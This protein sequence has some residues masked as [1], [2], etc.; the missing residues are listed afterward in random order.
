MGSNPEIANMENKRIIFS[1]EPDS[2]Q[3]LC[4]GTIKELT[5]GSEINAR[6]NH[7]NNCKTNLKAIF[8]L[9]C[10]NKPKISEV[11]EGD[12]QRLKPVDFV[13]T[14]INEQDYLKLDPHDRKNIFIKNILYKSLPWQQLNRQA[15][16][17]ILI[18]YY[19]KY[20]ENN[21][22]LPVSESVNK[23]SKEYC[24]N[25]D[26]IF[27]WLSD[28]YTKNEDSIIKLKEIFNEFKSSEQFLNLSF[29]QRAQ[30]MY[31]NFIAKLNTNVFLRKNIIQNSKEVYELHGYSKKIEEDD[32]DD[33]EGEEETKKDL[34]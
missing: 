11:T 22:Q 14:F 34:F 26:I 27:D 8:F 4:S 29:K 13:S 24:E 20:C 7:S 15:L 18:E 23:K 6:M 17:N 1:R 10:N 19:K 21:N 25:S 2:T 31:K 33:E 28:N 5:G 30:Y 32:D 3:E 12:Y 16:F 9:E